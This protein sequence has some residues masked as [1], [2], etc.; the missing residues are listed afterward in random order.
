MALIHPETSLAD[1]HCA[2]Y[3]RN[4]WAVSPCAASFG[5]VEFSDKVSDEDLHQLVDQLIIHS[6]K[7][8]VTGLRIVT[9]PDCY[10]PDRASR[11][12]KIF[13]TAGFAVAYEELNQHI[14]V[15]NRSFSERL[16]DAERRRLQKCQRAGF[17]AQIWEQ[18][19]VAVLADFVQKARIRKNRPLSMQSKE[20]ANLLQTFGDVC[21]VFTVR[22][23]EKLI[24]AC[25]GIRVSDDILYY[26][27]PADH[28][29]YQ[30][31]SPS[32]LLIESMYAYCQEQQ[33]ALL[34]LGISTS[35]G[36]RNEGLIRFKR[37]LGALESSKFV[38]EMRF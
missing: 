26:F 3:V 30:Q 36:V 9:Y 25:V 7:L 27:L 1:A 8:L 31:F 22:D 14:S 29:D 17:S 4:D 2:F 24:A 13:Q 18:P 33:I 6:K 12:H 34:D 11:I 21:T 15:D 35:G 19:D 16:Q 23:G 20:L 38:Y 10:A 32:V 37:H 28:E 5:S